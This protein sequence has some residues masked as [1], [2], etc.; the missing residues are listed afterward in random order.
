MRKI[1][2]YWY[3]TIFDMGFL[4]RQ[5]WGEGGISLVFRGILG[6]L[7]QISSQIVLLETFKISL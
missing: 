4:S 1:V 7:F 3:F 2:I 6:C 5:L